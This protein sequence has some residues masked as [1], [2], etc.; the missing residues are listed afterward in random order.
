VVIEPAG[1][2]LLAAKILAASDPELRARVAA[3]QRAQVDAL[4]AA[5]QEVTGQ[6]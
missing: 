6:T 3:A 4:L 2:A 5:D 1:A